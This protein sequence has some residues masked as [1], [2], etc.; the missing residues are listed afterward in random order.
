MTEYTEHTRGVDPGERTQSLLDEIAQQTERQ[1]AALERQADVLERIEEQLADA[2][3][4][5][6]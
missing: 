5:P 3:E 2:N 1:A 4:A 6:Q